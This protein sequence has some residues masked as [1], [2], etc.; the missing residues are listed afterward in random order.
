MVSLGPEGI[1]MTDDN[2]NGQE[3]KPGVGPGRNNKGQYMKGNECAKPYWYQKGCK[4]GPGRPKEGNLRKLI[5]RIL[6]EKSWK[7]YDINGDGKMHS[8]SKIERMVREMVDKAM[9]EDK[10]GFCKEIFDRAFGKPVVG[11]DL[12]AQHETT[13]VRQGERP[14]VM[15]AAEAAAERDSNGTGAN[16]NG[17]SNEAEPLG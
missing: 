2:G 5:I 15:T 4:G 16:G 13:Y 14:P 6:E 3:D 7:R 1:D 12:N 8:V 9:D 10:P 11:I 17:S